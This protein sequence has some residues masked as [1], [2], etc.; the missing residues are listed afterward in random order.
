MTLVETSIVLVVL[1]IIVSAV[2]SGAGLIR[3]ASGQKVFIDFISVWKTAFVAY[4]DQVKVPP[5]DN[6][7]APTHTITG[8]SG[9]QLCNDPGAPALTNVMLS[10]SIALPVGRGTGREDR[11]IY[12]DSNGISHELR[13]CFQTVNWSVASTTSGAFVL[14]P[15]HVMVLRGLTTELAQQ[16]DALTDGAQDARFG[17]FRRD[18]AASST[19]PDGV[20]WPPAKT[21]SGDDELAEIEAY[22][23]MN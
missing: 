8:P 3:L 18:V 15:R 12:Q 9:P 7:A 23:L 22:L 19:G 14:A 17:V 5:G 10:Q 16:I 6:P 4:V 21:V 2:A 11:Y 1:A 20:P 13:V